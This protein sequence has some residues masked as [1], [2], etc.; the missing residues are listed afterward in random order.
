VSYLLRLGESFPEELCLPAFLV[1]WE[2]GKPLDLPMRRS[3]VAVTSIM[4]SWWFTPPAG[5]RTEPPRDERERRQQ[6]LLW[7][8]GWSARF[9]EVPTYL[10]GRAT[11]LFEL[12]HTVE[13]YACG[14]TTFV[15]VLLPLEAN[16]D[17]A[18]Q[19]SDRLIELFD[20][21]AQDP[22]YHAIE[23]RAPELRD[24]VGTGGDPYTH[25]QLG[26]L[27]RRVR[28]VL[29]CPPF[30]HGVEAAIRLEA[31]DA[32]QVFAKHRA[33]AATVDVSGVT[34]AERAFDS[35]L[36]QALAQLGKRLGLASP[37]CYLLWVNC[38]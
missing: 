26:R 24:I 18:S 5:W 37:R 3:S 13:G 22:D 6:R 34:F 21:M 10:R 36:L 35:E 17:R 8:T 30:E 19:P 15:G 4:P 28:D 11:S 23:R 16:A 7:R 31:C 25:A 20:L 14:I 27:Y 1:G 2:S 38:D 12:Q 33:L 29:T 9:D 32:P